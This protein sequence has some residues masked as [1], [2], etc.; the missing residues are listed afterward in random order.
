[1][2]TKFISE[3]LGIPFMQRGVWLFLANSALYVA[4]S[5]MT[6]KPK[7]EDIEEVC[8]LNPLNVFTKEKLSGLTDPRV[9]GGGL[10]CVMIVLYWIMR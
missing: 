8:W 2:Q 10:F 6:P 5:F 7:L 3:D 4:V 1:M 9:L